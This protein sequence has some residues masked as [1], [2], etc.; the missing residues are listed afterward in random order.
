MA[1]VSYTEISGQDGLSDCNLRG[2]SSDQLVQQATPEG[3]EGGPSAG[4]CGWL[5]GWKGFMVKGWE[6]DRTFFRS[7]ALASLFAAI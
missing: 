6:K 1:T 2:Y 5:N 3:T 7:S 4:D